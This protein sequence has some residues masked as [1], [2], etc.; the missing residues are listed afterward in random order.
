MNIVVLLKMVPDVVEELKIGDDFKS[1]DSDWLRYILSE[2]DEHALEQAIILKEKYGGTITAVAPEAPEVDDALYSALAKGADRVVKIK[3]EWDIYRAPGL[4]FVFTRFIEINNLLGEHTLIL[5]GSQAIDDLEGE[6]VYYLAERLGLPGC[7]VVT[8]VQYNSDG[9][10]ITLLKE[11]SAGLRG[12]FEV[13]L[14]AVIGIQAAEN[15]PRY[16]PIAKIRSIMKT[17]KI[18]EI[19]IP[20]EGVPPGIAI[21]KLFEPV[22]LERAE[23]LEGNPEEVSRRLVEIFSEKGII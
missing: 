22:G 20:L 19:E 23:F 21:E 2:S 4:A 6:L 1:L 16:I 14:P 9:N 15:P 10:S 3:G 12:E 18:E 7:C 13:S 8:S 11:F 5:S 17:Q